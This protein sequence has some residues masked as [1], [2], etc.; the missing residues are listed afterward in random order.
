M[1]L[2]IGY[3]VENKL[4]ARHV[5]EEAMTQA[6]VRK[7]NKC[8]K[9]FLK[10]DGCNKI[11]CECGNK[12][13]YVCGMD[14][15]DYAHFDQSGDTTKC[16]L[17]GE[18]HELLH[19]QVA[20]AQ[21]RTVQELLKNR[22]ELQDDDIR[23]DKGTVADTLNLNFPFL[24]L[25]QNTALPDVNLLHAWRLPVHNEARHVYNHPGYTCHKCSRHFGSAHALSQHKTAKHLNECEECGTKFQSRQSL[26]LHKKA[27]H[28]NPCE[29]CGKMFGSAD[30]LDQ[31]RKD[32]HRK[33]QHENT[34]GD[35]GKSFRASNHLDQHRRDKHGKRRRRI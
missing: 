19:H 21:E 4:A 34:C 20:V 10:E 11:T 2:T 1:V 25:R 14:V 26:D 16:P 7:C 3:Q 31:H 23:V 9:V 22:G 12:Q 5:V 32:Q 17:Y 35:C 33:E 27:K 8:S 15:A 13:C 6:F 24:G 29:T 30:S 28:D 18:M